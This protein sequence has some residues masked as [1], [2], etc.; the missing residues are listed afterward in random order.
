MTRR[1]LPGVWRNFST[2]I[3][4]SIQT[5]HQGCLENFPTTTVLDHE[6]DSVSSVNSLHDRHEWPE[7]CCW[8][9]G[10]FFLFSI[11][12]RTMQQRRERGGREGERVGSKDSGGAAG[13]QEP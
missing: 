3:N 11:F 12:Y 10:G 2:A 13:A 9:L 8:A 6:L 7:G 1:T 5:K 4:K